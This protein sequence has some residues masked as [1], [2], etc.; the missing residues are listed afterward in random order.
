MARSE[1][2]SETKTADAAAA[3]P[4]KQTDFE[5]TIEEFCTRLSQTD[6]RVELIGAFCAAEI[7]SGRRKDR[8][9]NFRSRFAAFTKQP[10]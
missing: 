9:A 1:S 2:S 10:A 4:P 3:K 6:R 7:K 5:M 8:D